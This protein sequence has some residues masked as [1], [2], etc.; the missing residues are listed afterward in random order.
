MI[1]CDHCGRVT[2]PAHGSV[3]A[4]EK[5]YRLCH[6]S[7]FTRPDC[8]RLVTVYH[9]P[10]GLLLLPGIT[11][12]GTFGHNHDDDGTVDGCLGCFYDVPVA[13]CVV[14]K[15][16][17]PC[18]KTDGTCVHSCRAEDVEEVRKYQSGK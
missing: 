10:I 11:G 9:E 17:I 16:F 18:R 6:T 12:E 4:G 1:F 13:V 15:R 7:D 8:Y 2:G 14:H 3:T 5:T